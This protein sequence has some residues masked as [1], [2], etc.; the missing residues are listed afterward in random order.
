[1]NA[2]LR[3][4]IQFREPLNTFGYLP[5]RHRITANRAGNI[6]KSLAMLRTKYCLNLLLSVIYMCFISALVGT[7]FPSVA[8][9]D[10]GETLRPF[11]AIYDVYRRGDKLGEG[12]RTLKLLSDS[13]WEFS[14]R[15]DLSVFFLSDRR[16]EISRLLI[17][18]DFKIRPF[19]YEFKRTGTGADKKNC[20]TFN[21]TNGVVTDAVAN[22]V[23]NDIFWQPGVQDQ[24]SYQ[25]QLQV[26]LL[27]QRTQLEYRAINKKAAPRDYNFAT[28][29]TEET[30]VPYGT[31]E[32]IKVKR[33]TENSD[34]VT[35]AW[36]APSLSF[37]LV[38]LQQIED[39]K[40][41]Y[42]VRLKSLQWLSE[43]NLLSHN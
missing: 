29:S 13:A 33:I 41:S 35:Y 30:R 39:G 40:E 18:E 22:K 14:Y 20:L 5:Y 1:M 3:V 34:R 26:D 17:D 10:T 23:I 2:L 7:P 11:E 12:T 28:L 4:F 16:H 31:L 21:H 32:T 38:R 15:T 24:I 9:N 8:A 42:D 27:L 36:L 37:T 25:L 19:W 43:E 6:I